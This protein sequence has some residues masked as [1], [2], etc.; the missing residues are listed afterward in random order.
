MTLKCLLHLG[1]RPPIAARPD[2]VR[3]YERCAAAKFPI[4]RLAW[5]APARPSVPD[6]FHCDTYDSGGRHLMQLPAAV[7]PVGGSSSP[8]RRRRR[9]P[10]LIF[11]CSSR[12]CSKVRIRPSPACRRPRSAQAPSTFVQICDRHRPA[13]TPP[14]SLSPTAR[15]AAL[16]LAVFLSVSGQSAAV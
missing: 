3:V 8:G 11:T 13:T 5:N 7:A 14:P 4:R 12:R 6:S 2:D 9:Y 15:D 1:P 16:P 10:F